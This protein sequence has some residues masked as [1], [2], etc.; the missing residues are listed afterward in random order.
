MAAGKTV[1]RV[2]LAN[3]SSRLK[4]NIGYAMLPAAPAALQT[5]LTIDI[6]GVGERNATVVLIPFVDPGK[7]IPK[8]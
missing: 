6:P 4:K 8:H 5:P 3:W 2:T 7:E 1:R